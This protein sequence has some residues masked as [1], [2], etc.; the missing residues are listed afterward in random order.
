M[1]KFHITISHE[2]EETACAR[3]VKVLLE[4]GSHYLTNADFGCLDGDH[5]AWIMVDDVDT[6]VEALGIVPPAFREDAFVVQ[7]NRFS[8]DWIETFLLH[9]R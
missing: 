4:T 8:L 6:K 5:R 9:H 7:L 1:A 3:A 2:A